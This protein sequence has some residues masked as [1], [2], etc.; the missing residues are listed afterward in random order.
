MNIK[1]N[2]IYKIVC[3]FPTVTIAILISTRLQGRK[4]QRGHSQ[5][6][7][8]IITRGQEVP[9]HQIKVVMKVAEVQFVV[10][11]GAISARVCG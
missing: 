5:E 10:T 8:G 4:A 11:I 9:S 2:K 6:G 1:C 3:F 7:L